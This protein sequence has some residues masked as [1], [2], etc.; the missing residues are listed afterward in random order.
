MLNLLFFLAN[1]KIESAHLS[2]ITHR[3]ISVLLEIFLCWKR[4]QIVALF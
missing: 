1:D 2:F 3:S 4:E